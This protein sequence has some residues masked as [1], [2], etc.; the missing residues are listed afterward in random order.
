MNPGA[1]FHRAPVHFNPSVSRVFYTFGC[2]M[3][4]KITPPPPPPSS[5]C[6]SSSV[7]PMTKI[8]TTIPMFSRSNFSMVSAVMSPE[9][10]M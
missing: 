8:P 5:R 1:Q 2:P 7:A 10:D 4:G 9:V 6:I 3:G